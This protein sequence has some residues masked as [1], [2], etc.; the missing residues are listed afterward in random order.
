MNSF[1]LFIKSIYSPSTIYKSRFLPIGKAIMHLFLLAI[2]IN[3]SIYFQSALSING[4]LNTLNENKQIIPQAIVISDGQLNL[5]NEEAIIIS[6]NSN[7]IIVSN[8]YQIVDNAH[9]TLAF[10]NENIHIVA[11]NKEIIIPYTIIGDGKITEIVST[12]IGLFILGG[13][14]FFLGSYLFQVTFLFLGVSILAYISTLSKSKR[15]LTYRLYWRIASFAITN[16]VL[17]FSILNIWS[18]KVPSLLALIIL[19]ISNLMV[20]LAIKK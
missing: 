17:I 6:N 15:K 20:Y 7:D 1:A 16:T 18:I 10:L 19:L 14:L 11:A 13:I 3:M 8:D 9:S 2:V 12:N 4:L 5:N